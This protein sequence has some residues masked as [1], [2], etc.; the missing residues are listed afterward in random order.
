MTSRY[1][2]TVASTRPQHHTS[3][4]RSSSGMAQLRLILWNGVDHFG[5]GT[6]SSSIVRLEHYY[7]EATASV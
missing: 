7:G 2:D 4:A 1:V 3:M 6:L 5:A